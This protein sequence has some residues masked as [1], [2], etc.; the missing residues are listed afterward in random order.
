[1]IGVC[2]PVPC[3][4]VAMLRPGAIN[5]YEACLGIL[6]SRLG[7]GVFFPPPP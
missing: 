5:A 4:A 2:F 7:M 6:G 1:V 3:L